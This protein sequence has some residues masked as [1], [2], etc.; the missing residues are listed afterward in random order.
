MG[1]TKEEL[2]ANLN[3]DL[4][5]EF[6]AFIQYIQHAAAITGAQYESIQKELLVHAQEEMQHA[7]ALS[8]QID[9]LG[10]VPGV[11]VEKV[12]V[13]PDSLTMLK[14]DLA[15]EGKAIA[16]YTQRIGEA[17][18]LKLYGLRR[19]LEDILIQEEEHERD[20]L[21]VTEA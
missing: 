16:G 13:S 11:D 6:A 17:E 9:Y 21:S 18:S 15:G 5:W 12:E 2:I 20:L 8:E 10:G 4:A 14:Q 3:K 19:I 7:I 1:I